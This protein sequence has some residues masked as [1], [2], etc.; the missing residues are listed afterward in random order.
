MMSV[1]HR[2]NTLI[3]RLS[4]LAALAVAWTIE[5]AYRLAERRGRGEVAT[6]ELEGIVRRVEERGDYR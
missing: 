5:G 1:V 4:L 6:E 2:I 3:G